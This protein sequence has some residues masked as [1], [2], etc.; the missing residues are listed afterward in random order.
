[1]KCK[2]S[3][4]FEYDLL[5]PKTHKGEASAWAVPTIART[6]VQQAKSKLKPKGWVSMVCV[7]EREPDSDSEA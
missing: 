4:T 6:A 2:Y 1:M 7:L 5:P 3:V